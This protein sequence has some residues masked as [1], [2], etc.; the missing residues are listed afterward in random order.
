LRTN[1]TSNFFEKTLLQLSIFRVTIHIMRKVSASVLSIILVVTIG[2]CAYLL[3]N[4]GYVVR[5][6]L[7]EPTPEVTPTPMPT[8]EPTPEPVEPYTFAWMS[9]TQHY[10]RSFPDTFLAMTQYLSD[11]E[12]ALNLEY[13]IHTGDIVASSSKEYQWELAAEA[14][15][16]IAHIPAGWCA[17]NHDVSSKINYK[18]Y[19]LYFGEDQSDYRECYG[20]SY[21]D[22]RG[23]Y[24][25]I[26]AGS[27]SFIFLYMGYSVEQDGI[28]WMR[29]VLDQYPHR[30]AI[31]CTH[32]YFD[33]NLD[34]LSDGQMIQ[35]VIE[36]YPNVC[37]VLCGHRYN[38][39]EETAWYDDD[40]D[41]TPERP[42][43]QL[44]CNY[45]SAGSDGGSG[46]MMFMK[47]DEEKGTIDFYTYS[48]VT[49]DYVYFDDHSTSKGR[50]RN[51]PESEM[52][53]LEI[54]WEYG[55]E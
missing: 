4:F 50:Y 52:F 40:G 16:K 41:G 55:E 18:N 33:T 35:E 23:H 39:A 53:T 48:P 54:P 46:Y 21:R 6:P 45:Q 38:V 13:V 14:M 17:G 22:N 27:S 7:P 36:D 12:E 34:I 8:P 19:S 25:L 28:D 20:G 2:V 29:A 32:A 30:T 5:P 26:D 9:D 43:Y 47:V 24:D 51:A 11:N 31:I 49:D 10:S 44:I 1:C 15:D 3:H 37:M 42:V